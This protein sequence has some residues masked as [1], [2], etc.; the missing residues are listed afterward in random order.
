MTADAP[1]LVESNEPGDQPLTFLTPSDHSGPTLGLAPTSLGPSPPSFEELPLTV[2]SD[3]GGGFLSPGGSSD[4]VLFRGNTPKQYSYEDLCIQSFVS[5]ALSHKPTNVLPTLHIPPPLL[6]ESNMR[7]SHT[8][9]ELE[10]PLSVP[11]LLLLA[12]VCAHSFFW[13]GSTAVFRV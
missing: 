13:G 2:T 9:P 6:G 3:F 10:L 8:T 12:T 4:L 5:S 11:G 7:I 1:S